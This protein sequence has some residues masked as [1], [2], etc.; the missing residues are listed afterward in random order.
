MKLRI[1]PDPALLQA[2]EPV[3][4]F[5]SALAAQVEAMAA[6]MTKENGIGL[7]ANQVGFTNQVLIL[8][9]LSGQVHPLINPTLIETGKKLVRMREGCLSA[10]GIY[11]SILRPEEVAVEFQT[12]QGEKQTVLMAGVEARIFL[13][14]YEHLLGKFYFDNVN[15]AIRKRAIAE[16]RKMGK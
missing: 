2:C 8:R 5:D 14:E 10:P 9:D 4:S 12:L 1:Y 16:L 13:H 6:L 15:R 3:T 7:S 11:L